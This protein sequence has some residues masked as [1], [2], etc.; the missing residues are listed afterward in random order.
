MRAPGNDQVQ[1]LIRLHIAHLLQVC[2]RHTA[3]LDAGLPARGLNGDMTA[4]KEIF[5]RLEGR[6]RQ[7]IDVTVEEQKRTAVENAIQ[8]LMSETGVERAAAIEELAKLTP[9]IKQWVM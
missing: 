3:D 7:A 4:I 9:E 2:S 5:D 1:L 8:A 6:P